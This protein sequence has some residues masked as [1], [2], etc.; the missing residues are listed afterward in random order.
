MSQ[1]MRTSGVASRPASPADGQ[2]ANT[3]AMSA[4]WGVAHRGSDE[5]SD[6]LKCVFC[7]FDGSV[8][9]TRDPESRLSPLH[10]RAVRAHSKSEN[11]TAISF[12]YDV[13]NE[14]YR[15]WLS[16]GDLY[17]GRDGRSIGVN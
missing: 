10:G 15:L 5:A 12:H 14:F 16:R 8:A 2:A 1:P 9:M 3:A 7:G 11:R 17:V 4:T 13:S 6:L